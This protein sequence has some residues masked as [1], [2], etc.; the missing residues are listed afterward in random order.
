MSKHEQWSTKYEPS[1]PNHEAMCEECYAEVGKK[2]PENIPDMNVRLLKHHIAH[3]EKMTHEDI[4]RAFATIKNLQ[5]HGQQIYKYNRVLLNT[6][7]AGRT[8]L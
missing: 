8:S 2:L 5:D 6:N 3:N 4:V 7:G 1:V